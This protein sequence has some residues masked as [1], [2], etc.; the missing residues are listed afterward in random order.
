MDFK[1]I[2]GRSLE[3]SFFISHLLFSL[4]FLC[5]NSIP[6]YGWADRPIIY[7]S[8]S[9]SFFAINRL[10]EGRG[11]I[12]WVIAARKSFPWLLKEE[13]EKFYSF[14]WTKK[15]IFFATWHFRFSNSLNHAKGQNIYLS[16]K[17]RLS[18]VEAWKPDHVFYITT[19]RYVTYS[20][21][22]MF[23]EMNS[24]FWDVF[25]GNTLRNMLELCTLNIHFPY[26][27][28]MSVNIKILYIFCSKVKRKDFYLL[29][30]FVSFFSAA[31]AVELLPLQMRVSFAGRQVFVN[32]ESANDFFAGLISHVCFFYSSLFFFIFVQ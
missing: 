20:T 12:H 32:I 22:N 14:L 29:R 23:P 10:W 13:R 8:R 30:T 2:S 3:K 17:G 24:H 18:F 25:A 11:G 26:N 7:A 5:L 1:L 6:F 21:K 15:I 27:V 9:S 4:F 28:Q 31:V 16:H 19:G